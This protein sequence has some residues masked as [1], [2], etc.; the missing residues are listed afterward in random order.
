MPVRRVSQSPS[1]AFGERTRHTKRQNFVSCSF[2]RRQVPGGAEG[3]H[4]HQMVSFNC[5][6]CSDVV[7]KPRVPLA[8]TS[9]H[10]SRPDEPCDAGPEAH[11]ALPRPRFVH[12]LQQGLRPRHRQRAHGIAVGPRFGSFFSG[13]LTLR[14]RL[15]TCMSENDKYGKQTEGS[16]PANINRGPTHKVL[17]CRYTRSSSEPK[18]AVKCTSR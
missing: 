2:S 11:A 3:R 8:T 4:P 14:A 17:R 13:S 16:G 7:T 1:R 10:Q 9:V 5:E 15:Q 12:R 6:V 18:T